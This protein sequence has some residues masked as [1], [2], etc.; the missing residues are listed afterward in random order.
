MTTYNNIPQSLPTNATVQ[1]FDNYY[2]KPIQLNAGTFDAIR[3]FFNGKG[4]D[5]VSSET[6]TTAI[7]KQA[8]LGN[9]N[10]MQVLDSLKGQSDLALSNLVA[11][12]MNYSRFKTSLLGSAV[13]ASPYTAVTRNILA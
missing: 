3:G 2:V 8:Q 4:F 12:I 9:Y 5:S 7:M 10:P 13:S 1:A 6:I 11:E